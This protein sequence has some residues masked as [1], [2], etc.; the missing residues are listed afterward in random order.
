M[1]LS[2]QVVGQFAGEPS[3]GKLQACAGGSV[4][5]AVHPTNISGIAK[6]LIIFTINFKNNNWCDHSM[7]FTKV[8]F[9]ILRILTFLSM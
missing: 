4:T 1:S 6:Y 2:G 9:T 8:F 7:E 5:G 3:N